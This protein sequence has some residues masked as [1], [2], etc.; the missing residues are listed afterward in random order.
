MQP[1]NSKCLKSRGDRTTAGLGWTLS[2]PRAFTSSRGIGCRKHG[3]PTSTPCASFPKRGNIAWPTCYPQIQ[4]VW[5][6]F[7]AFP[8]RFPACSGRDR[9]CASWLSCCSWL[10]PPPPTPNPNG[11]R[12]PPSMAV[13]QV[14]S[15]TMWSGPFAERSVCNRFAKWKRPLGAKAF[16]LHGAFAPPRSPNG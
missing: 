14:G 6:T 3:D 5:V 9:L 10:P 15:E 7:E 4:P 12:S 8:A 16:R 1:L 2:R 11:R 13:V